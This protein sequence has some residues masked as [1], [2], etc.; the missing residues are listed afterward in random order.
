MVMIRRA[1][2]IRIAVAVATA[3][4]VWIVWGNIRPIPVVQDEYAYVLQSKIFADGRWTAPTPPVASAF[5]QPHVLTIPRVASKYPPGHSLLLAPGALL[6]APWVIVLVLSALSGLLVFT[7]AAAISERD[8]VGGVAW[9]VWL[10]DPLNLRFRPGY[11]SENT[12]AFLWLLAWWLLLRWTKRGD[13]RSLYALAI[14]IGWMAITRPL[15]ALAFAIPVGVLVVRECIAH[16]RLP[17]LLGAMAIGTVV[18]SVLLVWNVR[19]TGQWLVSPLSLYRAQYLPFDKPG[20][21]LDA[22][23][24]SLALAP[25]NADVYAE[26]AREHDGY[27]I[28]SVPRAAIARIAE[29]GKAQWGGWRLILLPLGLLGLAFGRRELWFTVACAAS[30]FIAYLSYAHWPGWALYYFE[31]SPVAAFCVAQGT[32]KL[33]EYLKRLAWLARLQPVAWAAFAI[34]TATTLL[35]WRGRHIADARYDTTFRRTL[36]SLPVKRAIVFVRYDAHTHPHTTIVSNS[37]RLDRDPM[38]IVID[39]PRTNRALLKQAG[40]RFPL[41][42][43]ENGG[44][45]RSYDELRD[46]TGATPQSP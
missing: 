6:N 32:V 37:A 15:T 41:L 3:L 22:T 39:D 20:F 17:S 8:W 38:W 12:S 36:N 4:V 14:A 18:L 21:G 29:L 46:S 10:G 11:Y 30:S 42:F 40:G 25:P 35:D 27:S 7:L 44:T 19:T 1:L 33:S 9:L 45:L 16:R 2:T 23:R 34:L 24:P 31:T 5:Q 26:F 43:E 28:A 13:A